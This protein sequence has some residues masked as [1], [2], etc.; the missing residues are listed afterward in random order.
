MLNRQHL[1][2]KWSNIND[3]CFFSGWDSFKAFQSCTDQCL[4]IIREWESRRQ[5]AARM[6]KLGK[7]A[8]WTRSFH[9]R[10]RT[11]SASELSCCRKAPSRPQL[12]APAFKQSLWRYNTFLS[13]YS[14]ILGISFGQEFVYANVYVM[15]DTNTGVAYFRHS[16]G[17]CIWNSVIIVQKSRNK[18]DINLGW[19]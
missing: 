5:G 16:R 4:H 7:C 12:I 18:L 2:K 13:G 19:A 10:T 3:V 8:K 15:S 6:V 14:C 9:R 1:G 17:G 11:C